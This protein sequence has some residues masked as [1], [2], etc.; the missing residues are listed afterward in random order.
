MADFGYVWDNKDCT[1]YST[2]HMPKVLLRRLKVLASQ[3]DESVEWVLNQAL[4][5]GLVELE[6]RLK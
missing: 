6:R 4:D 2:R 1:A 5:L 3:V